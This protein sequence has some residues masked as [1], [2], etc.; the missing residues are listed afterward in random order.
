M[1][2]CL[3]GHTFDE[4]T[5]P[6]RIHITRFPRKAKVTP[7]HNTATSP[8]PTP[9]RH[10]SPAKADALLSPRST[11]NSRGPSPTRTSPRLID[12][13]SDLLQAHGEQDIDAGA[14]INAIADAG[15]HSV[16][17]N[18]DL[19]EDNDREETPV[20]ITAASPGP[21][22]EIK[23]TST[24]RPEHAG[25]SP[26]ADG[27]HLRTGQDAGRRSRSP[28]SLAPVTAAVEAQS[29]PASTN[30]A[31][32]SNTPAPTA[33]SPNTSP[34]DEESTVMQDTFTQS[35]PDARKGVEIPK[36]PDTPDS[37]QDPQ[38]SEQSSMDV[39][40]Q[41][42]SQHQRVKPV[43]PVSRDASLPKSPEDGAMRKPSMRID[44]QTDIGSFFRPTP[45]H[46]VVE[47]PAPMTGA[48]ATPRRAPPPTP[49]GQES[50]KRAT[51]ISSGVLQKKSV[52]EILGETP[53]PGSTVADSPMSGLSENADKDR[54]EKER[55]KLSTVVFAKP[56]KGSTDG[57]TIEL[58]R[59]NA[60]EA[61]KQGSSERDYLYTLFEN[62]AYSMTRQ[63]SMSYL[64]QNAHK[65]LST[66]DHLVDY[67]MQ[68]EC[69]ILKR[70]YQLQE[71]GRWALRQYKRADEAPRPTSHWDFLLDH[72]KWM[73]TDF[74]EERKWKMAAARGL[75]GCCAE[76]VACS[77]EQRKLLQVKV[78][79]P[80]IRPVPDSIE[81]AEM[82]DGPG[83]ALSSHP[84]PDLIPSNEDESVSDEIADPRDVRSIVPPAAI[85]S[86][87]AADFNFSADKTPAF[88]KLLNE[89]PLYE[90][91][92]IEPDLSKS[93]LAEQMD[94]RWKTDI[95]PVSKYATE[96]LQARD[97]EPPRKRSRYDYELE[98]PPHRKTEPLPPRD[99]NVA[100]FMP[101]NKH[102]RDRIHPGHSFRPPSEHPMP[103]QA[104]FETRN[105]SQWTHSEDDELRKLV[106]DYSYNW[107][108]ISSCLTQRSLYASG[109]DRR[110]PW[111]C[112]ERW[113]GLEGL[114]ADMSKTPYFKTY[115]GRIEAAGRHVAAQ[116][117]EAQR[118]AGANVQIPARK[119][120]TQPVRVDRKRTQRH[121]AM[122][123][124]M[125]KLA[126]KRETYAQKQQHQADLA[127]MRKVNEV[128]QPKAPFKTPAEFAALKQER[129]QKRAEQQEIYRQQLIAHQRAAAQQQRAQ[130][131]NGNLPNGMPGSLNGMRPPSGGMPGM[132]NGNLQVPNGQQRPHPAMMGMMNGMQL[133]PGMMGP[134]HLAQMQ[135]QIQ[136]NMARG[137]PNTSPQQMRML[138]EAQKVQQQQEQLL[139]QQAQQNGGTHSSPTGPHASL[140]NGN[141][142]NAAYMAAMANANG[143]A[144][145]SGAPNGNSS[146]PRSQ[147]A[148][149]S[150]PLSSGATPL[151]S[152]FQNQ[153]R[154]QYP[155]MSEED[156]RRQASQKLHAHMQMYQQT[157]TQAAA[158]QAPKRPQPHNQ[159][160]VNAAMG[161]V[162]AAAHA[163]NSASAAM[164]GYGGGQS[165]MTNEQVQQF[166]NQRMR[167]AQ[168]QAQAQAQQQVRNGM[169]V[170][171]NQTMMAGMTQ[172]PVMNMARPVSQHGMPQMSRSATPRDQRSGSVGQQG[173]PRPGSRASGMQT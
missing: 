100:L 142:N 21:R 130:G 98:S 53:K 147:N 102:I 12:D 118:R 120:T 84:T 3:R 42:L 140:A 27:V 89:L 169:Q 173:S 101:D 104:F 165:M 58:L 115:S 136:A 117:E 24:T 152:V 15:S 170:P 48:S 19:Q 110:T 122:L 103:T 168:A 124:A 38:P 151:I 60:E 16:L 69:R 74:R 45:G 112:F 33:G 7:A 164:Q 87:D 114:P 6:P 68:T 86:L 17:T 9:K 56:Q 65:T 77:Q 34:D 150:G 126:K 37:T 156:I 134:K 129:E 171:I 39:D 70:L 11:R 2:T 46:N 145:P 137:M 8:R 167:M 73:R 88:E 10:L 109:S 66:A 82:T 132:P 61:Q 146:S 99:L 108:L 131:Q 76:F 106:K 113:I 67:Q 138:Q 26:Q 85:F 40:H 123:D 80:T 1:L 139:R 127:A 125:R 29:S 81:D 128:N 97:V 94:A 20:R 57:D 50:S 159:A 141:M 107:S 54:R 52:S 119:R 71:K 59:P 95:V 153:L 148:N 23:S 31:G 62:K 51:R 78:R 28:L 135:A 36:R 13:N 83:P 63:G 116:I 154:E 5:L 149:N 30:E 166:N 43:E 64:I 90:P 133:P 96:K 157:A 18:G 105:S 172:S 22:S 32:S 44:T 91:A 79:P 55:S 155:N 4:D 163:S 49:S 144:S 14:T 47:S 158:G 35:K 111:E 161:A 93:T 41:Q 121:L 72:A 25:E 143:A 160:A 75:A 162:N 92:T